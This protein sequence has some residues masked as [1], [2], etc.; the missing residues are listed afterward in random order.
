MKN[1]FKTLTLIFALV[2][3]SSNTFADGWYKEWRSQRQQR[4]VEMKQHRHGPGGATGAPIDAGILAL[5]GAA[6][7]A[8]YAARKKKK[9]Q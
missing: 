2:F 6:G 4:Q 3:I 9:S 8:Y 1:Y 5:L 7:A